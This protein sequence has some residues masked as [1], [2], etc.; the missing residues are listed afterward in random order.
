[1]RMEILRS[2]TGRLAF[3]PRVVAS[4]TIDGKPDE[5]LWQWNDQQPWFNWQSAL[6]DTNRT[7][8]AFA[9]DDRYLY[10]ALR[11]PQNDL[12]GQ[13]RC[14]SEY[15]AQAYQFPSVEIFLNA[16]QPG[17]NAERLS[18]YQVIPA[19]GGGLLELGKGSIPEKPA[20]VSAYAMSDDAGEWR[21]ELKIDL[22]KIGLSP[23]QYSW[24]RLNLVRNIGVGGFIG[25]SWFP[26]PGAHFEPDSRGWLILEGAGNLLANGDLAEWNGSNTYPLSWG[27]MPATLK[28]GELTRE[29]GTIRFT[30]ASQAH[31]LSQTVPVRGGVNYE[32]SCIKKVQLEEHFLWQAVQWRDQAGKGI[33]FSMELDAGYDSD[34]APMRKV[35]TAPSN[36]V[37]ASVIVGPYCIH[38]PGEVAKGKFWIRNVVFRPAPP[39]T[40]KTEA[41]KADPQAF[42]DNIARLQEAS[43][44]PFGVGNATESDKLYPDTV[45]TGSMDGPIRL[46]LAG[47]EYGSFQLAV[48]PFEEDLTN[49]S[50]C[51]SPLRP[52]SSGE[53]EIAADRFQ[54]FRVAYVRLEQPPSWLGLTYAH[55][56]EPDPLLPA[57]PFDV[58]KGTVAAVWVDVFLPPGT[59]PG[60]Y[61]GTVTV[62]A[63][64][65]EVARMAEVSSHGFDIPAISSIENDFWWHPGSWS[66]F[67]GGM[68]YTPELHAKHAAALGR[69][70]VSSF[71]C[72]WTVICPQVAI[73]AE[74]DGRFTF[75]WTTFDRYVKNALTNGTTAFWSALSCNSGWTVYLHNPQTRVIERATGKSVELGRYIPPVSN[76]WELAKLPYRENK[77][78]R[79]FLL[80]YVAHLKE[81]GIN[82]RAY[83]ELFD[84]PSGDRFAAML[85]HHAFFRELVP[86]LKLFDFSVWP[87]RTIDG[88]NAVGLIDVWAP[89]IDVLN[90]PQAMAVMRARREKRGEK[91][92]FYSC[93]EMRRNP[94]GKISHQSRHT[95]DGYSPFCVYHRPYIAT[96]IQSW[97]AWEYQ[98]DGFLIYMLSQVL[99]VNAKAQPRWPAS[100]WSDGGCRGSGTLV[101]PG[102][103]YG[104]VPGMRLANIREGLEDYEY[105]ALLK[106]LSATLGKSRNA[107]LL[108]R[109]ERAL[110]VDDDIVGSVF[111]WTKDRERLEA[112]RAQLAEL[113]R[114]GMAAEK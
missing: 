57:A 50:V 46:A 109:I 63:N 7:L 106:K 48:I 86:D 56:S 5:S 60:V 72:D 104:I 61:T 25:K 96:R 2:M 89:H 90:D 83:Y 76:C 26:S 29:D 51:F 85:D 36:A 114:E 91:L 64:G 27:T 9:H 98:F 112:K 23:A 95:E 59:P 3:A 105:F 40:R 62:A 17:T 111:D 99:E 54:W 110:A 35:F 73:Y 6:P 19:F 30:D 41:P 18:Y 103:D 67:Y 113:I 20:A 75:D 22:R 101:Y 82:D 74:P 32:F 42:A 10:L 16:D 11:C 4:P 55:A 100:E 102:P 97:M 49:A 108:Q 71:P 92:W 87:T 1:K 80:A 84:E 21:A 14:P 15:G 68:P 70:R 94:N 12:A 107:E 47:G 37:S 66:A 77:V 24:L 53:G 93:V 65:K 78:Y 31:Q 44:K 69:Y 38:R 43:G 79:D 8:F 45:Y 52:G 13:K 34:F 58:K 81:L 33:G 39:E 28:P 88:R